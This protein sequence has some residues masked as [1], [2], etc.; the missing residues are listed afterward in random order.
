[1][2]PHPTQIP[3]RMD[4]SLANFEM[5]REFDVDVDMHLDFGPIADNITF[6]HVCRRTDEYT[7]RSAM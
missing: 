1:M 5:A 2:A 7:S 3:I 6:D 4:R